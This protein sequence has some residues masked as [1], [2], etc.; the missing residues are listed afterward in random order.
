MP[1]AEKKLL[2]RIAN[3]IGKY[4]LNGLPIVDLGT[5]GEHAVRDKLAPIISAVQSSRVVLVDGSPSLLA[6]ARNAMREI[7]GISITRVWDDFLDDNTQYVDH[8]ALVTYTGITIGNIKADNLSATPPTK[9][10]TEHITR[11]CRKSH[12]GHALITFDSML[13]EDINKKAYEEHEY[14]H[15]NF[16]D[17]AV[18]EQGF[19]LGVRE[20][21]TYRAIPHT[22]YKHQ[23][24]IAGVIG[25]YA[26]FTDDVDFLFGN[27]R[28]KF[29]AN[30]R[31]LL[32][33][34]FKYSLDMFKQCAKKAEATTIATWKERSIIGI[35]LKSP[36]MPLHEIA[37]KPYMNLACV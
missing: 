20:K 29:E 35:L 36:S 24:P 5:G 32:K 7:T 19:P 3:E 2:P 23:K 1:C 25:H 21:I 12:G 16:L 9:E 10:L 31:L 22:W 33:N 28:F 4:I 26:E 18:A 17:C 15:L 13:D 11:V 30:S 37:H 27:E 8:P 14:F 6:Q 34:S